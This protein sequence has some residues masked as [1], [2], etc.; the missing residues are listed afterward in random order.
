MKV[1]IAL[2]EVGH[3]LHMLVVD[4]LV[5]D[6]VVVFVVVVKHLGQSSRSRL[7][8][9]RPLEEAELEGIAADP[10]V[11]LAVACL[12]YLELLALLRA[13]DQ[14]NLATLGSE[15]HKLLDV[16]E[17]IQVAEDMLLAFLVTVG[18][19]LPCQVMVAAFLLHQRHKLEEPEDIADSYLDS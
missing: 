2:A 12:A 15:L 14:P 10:L 9:L 11:D 1:G 17:E 18:K 6:L 4:P 7:G 19:D 3:S 8:H 13:L 16:E 5:E